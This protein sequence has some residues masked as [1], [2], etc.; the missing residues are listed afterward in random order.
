MSVF[1]ESNK[2]FLTFLL[3]ATKNQALALL[4]DLTINQT[5]VIKETLANLLHLPLPN[6]ESKRILRQKNRLLRRLST[7]TYSA[8]KNQQLFKRHRKLIFRFIHSVKK[9]L[10]DNIISSQPL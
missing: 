6:K 3:S 4:G 9:K 8:R 7:T 2:P 1:L 5:K 10:L